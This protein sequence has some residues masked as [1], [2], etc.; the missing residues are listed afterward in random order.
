MPRCLIA[1]FSQG[2]STARVAEHIGEGLKRAAFQVDFINIKDQPAPD[3]RAYDLLGA[4][5][6]AYY[7]RLPFNT[8]SF[9]KQLPALNHL[10]AFAFLTHG[11]Y[12]GDAGNELRH[13]L[14]RKGTREIGYFRCYGADFFL[15]YLKREILFSPDHPTQ[16]E[17]GRAEGF[18]SLV[19]GY[20][21]GCAYLAPAADPAPVPI[22]RLERF[23]TNRWFAT[24]FYSRL[25]RVSAKKCHACGLCHKSCPTRNLEPDQQGRPKWGRNCLLCLSCEMNCPNEAILSPVSWQMFQPFLRYN[26]KKG[27]QDPQLERILATHCKGKIRRGQPQ[28]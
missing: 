8:T 14:A 23:L 7:F 22:Y 4:G 18:G 3:P 26:V 6:P 13:R 17:L 24:Q 27:L 2:G 11:T 15:G 21:D 16:E 28:S 19:A 10:P 20:F 5:S 1:F 9:L 12:P 25:F